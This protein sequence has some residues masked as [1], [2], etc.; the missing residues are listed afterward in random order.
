M[1]D[2]I[3]PEGEIMIQIPSDFNR[4]WVS[5]VWLQKQ[6]DMKDSVSN[7][8]A[9]NFYHGYKACLKDLVSL[10]SKEEKR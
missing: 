1:S 3:K 5:L 2:H 10:L 7:R 8:Y 4:K 9:G 6:L